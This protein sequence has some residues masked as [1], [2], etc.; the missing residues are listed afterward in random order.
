MWVKL[1]VACCA[2]CA[3]F[4]GGYCGCN[5]S[6]ADRGTIASGMLEKVRHTPFPTRYFITAVEILANFKG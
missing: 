3:V 1:V 5:R 2:K 4:G 6:K